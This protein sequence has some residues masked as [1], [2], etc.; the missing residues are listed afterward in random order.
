MPNQAKIDQVADITSKLESAKSCALIQYQG[1][2]AADVSALRDNVR[3]AG[4]KIEVVKNSL[5]ARA[6]ANIG[7]TLPETL[8][9]PTA[10]TFCNE[11]EV[12]PLKEI[13]KVNKDHDFI[14]FKYGV[15]DKKLL[16][17]D[18]LKQFISLPSK[19][20]LM[21]QLLGGLVNP[22]Q[23]LAY[24]LKYNQTQL[25]LALKAV[26]DKQEQN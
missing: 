10:I 21:A 12:N 22:L 16:G 1:L 25:A 5:I 15:Y 7:I 24:G 23:R 6:F 2:N 3:A 18:E 11:D 17:F 9:G 8:T 14:T 26:A 13:D 19:S 20:A 4:G